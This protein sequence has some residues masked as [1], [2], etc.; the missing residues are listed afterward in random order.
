MLSDEKLEYDSKFLALAVQ[1]LALNP[2][3]AAE[4]TDEA[5]QRQASVSDIAIEKGLMDMTQADAIRAMVHPDQ[6][7]PGYEVLGIL[8]QGGLG[9]VFSARQEKLDRIVALK[10]ILLSQMSHQDAVERFK[11][12]ARLIAKLQHPN[13][14]T[15][16][17]YGTH[18]GRLYLAME[19]VEGE[20]LEHW[21]KRA[22]R[23]NEK[24]AWCLARQVAAGLAHAA[25]REIV[26][27][28]IKPANLLITEPPD[29]FHTS[30]EIPLV[31]ITD[32]GLAF[33][34]DESGQQTRLTMAGSLMGTPHYMAPEQLEATNVDHRADIYALGASVYHM[35]AGQPPFVGKTTGQVLAQKLTNNTPRLSD[36]AP[37]ISDCTAELVQSMME[38]DP[39]RRIQDYQS[40][41][42]SIDERLERWPDDR[43][44]STVWHKPDSS[45]QP[46]DAI[47][48]ETQ[49]E[50]LAK[51][52][53]TPLAK[54][55][56]FGKEQNSKTVPPRTIDRKH[57]WVAALV[58]LIL[59]VPIGWFF[60]KRL[61]FSEPSNPTEHF[62]P[63]SWMA[64]LNTNN[65]D[66][67]EG[68]R[69]SKGRWSMGKDVEGGGVLIGNGSPS[70]VMIRRLP[71]PKHGLEN[72]AI[73]IGVD[74]RQAD[75]AELQFGSLRSE[76]PWE[77]SRYVVRILPDSVVFGLLKNGASI[78]PIANAPLP[79]NSRSE[80]EPAYHEIK[81]ERHGTHWQAFVN[82][83]KIGSA[84]ILG[85]P[86]RLEIRLIVN[87][88]HALFDLHEIVELISPTNN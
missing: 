86:E 23:L 84:P 87:G 85:G 46:N 41:I 26:H 36:V 74:G 82:G 51:E 63:S 6:I 19:L 20:D 57:R 34:Y 49:Q 44:K 67:S 13:V 14:I 68:W 83:M 11:Q 27:R 40:L 33:F 70:A 66:P 38:T 60:A 1:H 10:T 42:A 28:D 18:A 52:S 4:V 24:T 48:H 54:P 25:T 31:K 78:Q 7:A 81:I 65:V 43:V 9:I 17:D 73:R 72:Y 55:T 69:V 8:G 59:S 50:T 47:L 30:S 3:H 79:S 15:A 32:F 88:D 45:D 76:R 62:V 5:L 80:D 53:I 37:E 71:Q 35:L 64:Y 61:V 21:I 2:D 12:E 29:G 39:D 16:Y 58:L 22:G 56:V 75:Y 77:G